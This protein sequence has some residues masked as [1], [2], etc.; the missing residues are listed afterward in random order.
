MAKDPKC[1][2][3]IGKKCVKWEMGD[4]NKITATVN[5]GQCDVKTKKEIKDTLG[6]SEGLKIKIV[7]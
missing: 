2:E 7:D 3:W 4:D 6:R 5:F 1:L